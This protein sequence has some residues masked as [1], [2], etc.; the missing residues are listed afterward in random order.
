MKKIIK[1]FS[2][3]VGAIITIV[4]IGLLITYWWISTKWTDYYSESEIITMA[5]EINSSETLPQDFYC[6]YDIIY[7]EQRTKSLGKMTFGI[8][9]AVVIND[10]KSLYKKQCNSIFASHYF[11]NRVPSKF[12]SFTS[13]ITAHGI[14]KY[15]TEEKCLDF[16]YRK[17]LIQN[18]SLQ[19]FKK[20]LENLNC[21]ENIELILFMTSPTRYKKRPDLLRKKVEPFIKKSNAQQ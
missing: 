10:D 16:I 21:E 17:S 5:D 15:T 12:H 3:V 14:E 1:I 6:A 9:W 19:Y 18:F 8:I 20:S 13:F 2:W 11:E 4:V 7:P